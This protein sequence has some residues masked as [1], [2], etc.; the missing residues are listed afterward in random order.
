[1]KENR[2]MNEIEEHKKSIGYIQAVDQKLE[3]LSADEQLQL[4]QEQEA[5][6]TPE[7]T[8][9]LTT[10]IPQILDHE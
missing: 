6:N 5:L 10:T 1:M 8:D 4:E 9:S 3:E 7:Q 2:K